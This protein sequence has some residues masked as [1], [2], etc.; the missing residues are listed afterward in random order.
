M[1]ACQPLCTR[2]VVLVPEK[3]P[4]S[5]LFVF[6]RSI[7]YTY[8]GYPIPVLRQIFGGIDTTELEVAAEPERIPASRHDHT[9][10]LKAVLFHPLHAIHIR[11]CRLVGYILAPQNLFLQGLFDD[12]QTKVTAPVCRVHLNYLYF[13]IFQTYRIPSRSRKIVL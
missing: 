10:Y 3:I 5:P 11:H 7:T 8:S 6:G 12:Y 13:E 1:F 9:A 4:S 2:S